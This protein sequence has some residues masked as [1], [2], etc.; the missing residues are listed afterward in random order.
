MTSPLILHGNR[1]ASSMGRG[2]NHPH[3]A[4]LVSLRWDITLFLTAHVP[5]GSKPILDIMGF[6][7]SGLILNFESP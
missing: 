6:R 3:I 7:N 5:L 4:D 1:E 2:K